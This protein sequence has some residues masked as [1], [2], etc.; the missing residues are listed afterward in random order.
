MS[1]TIWKDR[2]GEQRWE[3]EA[4]YGMAT[5]NEKSTQASNGVKPQVCVFEKQTK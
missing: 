5:D 4:W 1:K 2:Q 3:I